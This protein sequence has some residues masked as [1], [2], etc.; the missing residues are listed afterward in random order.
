MSGNKLGNILKQHIRIGYTFSLLVFDCVILLI[1]VYDALSYSGTFNHSI[2]YIFSYNVLKVLTLPPFIFLFTLLVLL[3]IVVAIARILLG[4]YNF[5]SDSPLG[6]RSINITRAHIFLSVIIFLF[7]LASSSMEHLAGNALYEGK[8]I[9]SFSSML[10][11]TVNKI[12][13]IVVSIVTVSISSIGVILRLYNKESMNFYLTKCNLVDLKSSFYPIHDRHIKNFNSGAIAPQT[14]YV[15]DYTNGLMKIYQEKVPTSLNAVRFLQKIA[16]DCNLLLKEIFLN[17][18]NIANDIEIMYFTSTS[19]A[20]EVSVNSIDDLQFIIISPYEHPTI[21]KIAENICS[22]RKIN[23]ITL[24]WD[25]SYY[26]KDWMIQQDKFVLLLKE[27]ISDLANMRGALIISEV[28][29]ANGYIIEIEEIIKITNSLDLKLIIDGSHSVG[30]IKKVKAVNLNYYSYFFSSHKWLQSPEPLGILLIHKKNNIS[31]NEYDS[32]SVYKLPLTTAS[33]TRIASLNASLELLKTMKLEYF[34]HRSHEL[35]KRFVEKIKDRFDI[36]C[37]NLTTAGF[38][39]FKKYSS[40]ILTIIL[41]PEYKWKFEIGRI[42]EVFNESKIYIT[43]IDMCED[44]WLRFTF[45]Y[46]LEINDIDVTA[47]FLMQKTEIRT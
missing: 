4:G 12:S 41:K 21:V 6:R 28:F 29:Y 42:E 26:T 8:I 31:I 37:E 23:L 10:L 40:N 18:A 2:E 19:R 1:F 16:L 35:K 24:P 27:S 34:W 20:F 46:F 15:R 13:Y 43:I 38:G 45:S 33:I 22:R 32:W 25:C 5:V 44:K 39:E 30:N 36:P 7:V 3:P 17:P 47:K 11:F 14:R 9:L